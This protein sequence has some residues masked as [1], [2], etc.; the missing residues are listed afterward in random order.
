MGTSSSSLRS[1][2]H[3]ETTTFDLNT[4]SIDIL[5]SIPGVGQVTFLFLFLFL[6]FFFNLYGFF[7]IQRAAENIVHSRYYLNW[8]QVGAVQGVDSMK[9]NIL[10]G[11]FKLV[12][13]HLGVD[14]SHDWDKTVDH[15]MSCGC[16]VSGKSAKQSCKYSSTNIF[17]FFFF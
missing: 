4:C 9:L 10:Q 11:Y 7:F 6:F 16:V 13:P 3:A 14:H 15:C 2:F 8:K 12:P 17:L 5:T 1:T